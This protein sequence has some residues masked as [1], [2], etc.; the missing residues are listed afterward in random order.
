MPYFW[1]HA[2]IC[3]FLY[4]SLVFFYILIQQKKAPAVWVANLL[5]FFKST[6]GAQEEI[7][8]FWEWKKENLQNQFMF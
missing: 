2:N 8:V 3:V 1:G 4:K 5:I 6:P 7:W